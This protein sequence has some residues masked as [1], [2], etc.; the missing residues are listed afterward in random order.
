[1]LARRLGAQHGT[2]R[3]QALIEIPPQ[4]D[5]QLSRQGDDADFPNTAIAIAELLLVPARELTLGLKA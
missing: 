1:V 4:R 5:Q 2:L 3:E